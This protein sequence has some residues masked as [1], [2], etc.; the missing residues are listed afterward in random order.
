MIHRTLTLFLRDFGN[1]EVG[2]FGIAAKDDLLYLEDVELV[3][4][5][6]SWA[7]VAFDDESVADFFDRQVDEGRRPEQFARIWLH[8]HPGD[9]PL[10][11][12]V[13]EETFDRVFGR[14]TWAIMFILACEGQSYA[15]L[16]FND[17]PG[18][19]L[20]IPVSVD[21][22]RPFHCCDH[23]AWEREYLANVH[24]HQ[25]VPTAAKITEPICGSPF[26]EE[27]HD[28]WLDSWCD[29]VED[30]DAKGWDL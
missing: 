14:S 7:H 21:Y 4:Q 5:T 8:T 29:Y 15:R 17:G 25:P 13:D 2:G 20:E 6:C 19:E 30:D 10:P 1:T 27:Q 28:E 16:R 24:V 18:A 22:T 12:Q 23:P 26:D 3:R 9:S 11:S